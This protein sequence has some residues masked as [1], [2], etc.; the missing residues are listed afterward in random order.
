VEA[1]NKANQ[2][3]CSEEVEG[4]GYKSPIPSG[5]C[6]ISNI[7]TAGASVITPK[8]YDAKFPELFSKSIPMPRR[9]FRRITKESSSGHFDEEASIPNTN[10]AVVPIS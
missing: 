2:G 10:V 5:A 3:P 7:P 9:L 8:F 6:R 1:V 4:G